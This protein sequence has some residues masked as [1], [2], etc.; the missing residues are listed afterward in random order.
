MSELLTLDIG[1]KL[2][3]FLAKLSTTDIKD[4]LEKVEAKLSINQLSPSSCNHDSLETYLNTTNQT[5]SFGLNIEFLMN[6]WR[7]EIPPNSSKWHPQ[8]ALEWFSVQTHMCGVAVLFGLL[9]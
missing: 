8:T 9:W 6:I 5:T 7:S 3:I 1:D 4:K 2:E